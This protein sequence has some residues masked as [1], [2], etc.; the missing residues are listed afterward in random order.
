MWQSARFDTRQVSHTKLQLF[1]IC[2][3]PG[4]MT[5]S[6]EQNQKDKTEATLHKPAVS[7]PLEG[8][9]AA[10]SRIAWLMDQI[11]ELKQRW[12]AHSTPAGLLQRL[13]EL[14]EEL[15]EARRAAG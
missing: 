8:E 14:E 5:K 3:R 4:D 12:P 15:E 2:K 10:S 1:F 11:E 9:L 6:D 7:S 13:D